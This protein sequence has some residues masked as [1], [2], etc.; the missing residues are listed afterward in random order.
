MDQEKNRVLVC[1]G[2]G[3][4]SSG[5][6]AVARAFREAMKEAGLDNKVEVVETG[7][8]GACDL[9][10]AVVVVRDGTFYQHVAPRDVP[11]IVESHLRAGRPV[12]RLC[13]RSPATGVPEAKLEDMGFFRGQTKVVLRNCGLIDPLKIDDYI[14]RRGYEALA[15]VLTSMTPEQVIQEVKDSGLRGRGGAGFPTGVKWMLTAKAEGRPKY[16]VC[17]ADEGDPG[18][19]MDRSVLEG[20]PHSVI[21]AM[22]I[23]GYAVGSDQGF[24]YVRAEY[25]LAIERLS[26]AIARQES[27]ASWATASSAAASGL[28]SR[29][30]SGPARL[31]AARRRR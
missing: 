7:C 21:E 22:I 2:A 9:G 11:D 12:E 19:F 15:K 29:S 4:V 10:P 18:A 31:S 24:V 28:T 27:G 8:I 1:A 6:K 3:C 14:A 16:V 20:D 5:C 13:H 23:A 30:E 17:N 26:H 25:P